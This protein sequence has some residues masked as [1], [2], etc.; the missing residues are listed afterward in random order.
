MILVYYLEN[1]KI[2]YILS[3]LSIIVL[4]YVFKILGQLKLFVMIFL[5]AIEFGTHAAIQ[6][7]IRS[8]QQLNKFE[9]DYIFYSTFVYMF[10]VVLTMRL[11]EK[12]FI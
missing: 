1:P 9:E 5:A 7:Y 4:G 2:F 10:V 6:K 12:Y 8:H 3:A 11:I